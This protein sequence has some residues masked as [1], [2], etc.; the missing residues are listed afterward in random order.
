MNDTFRHEQR[1][2][3]DAHQVPRAK[4]RSARI[5]CRHA[6]EH[7]EDDIAA[8]LAEVM[9]K[10]RIWHT[11]R[12][13]E[14]IWRKPRWRVTAKVRRRAVTVRAHDIKASQLLELIEALAKVPEARDLTIKGRTRS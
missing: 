2:S 13:R 11:L 7:P 4:L 6:A 10:A 3:F 9:G 8:A 12:G 1:G 14:L 5:R